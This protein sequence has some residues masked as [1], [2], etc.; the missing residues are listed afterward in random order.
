MFRVLLAPMLPLGTFLSLAHS[1][2]H[3]GQMNPLPYLIANPPANASSSV[4][5]YRGEYFEIYGPIST[6]LYSEVHWR[7][8]PV[9]LPADIVSRYRGKVMAITGYEVRAAPRRA[10][11]CRTVPRPSTH[12]RR[13]APISAPLSPP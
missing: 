2:L 1:R 10:A 8:H 5:H 6:S 12:P 4:R 13:G 3:G 7:S 11:P 9:P